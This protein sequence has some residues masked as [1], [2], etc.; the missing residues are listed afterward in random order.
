MLSFDKNGTAP[1]QKPDAADAPQVTLLPPDAAD[2]ERPAS[3]PGYRVLAAPAVRLGARLL[4]WLAIL[5]FGMTAALTFGA[6]LHG[7]ALGVAYVVIGL[8]TAAYE[9][10]MVWRY[11]AT[12]GKLSF[13]VQVVQRDQ[14][15]ET[16]GFWR[17]TA[18]WATRFVPSV[19]PFW[20]L[21]DSI[22]LLW[23]RP[24]YQCPHDKAAKTVV[25]R[26]P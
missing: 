19:V 21:F 25:V 24:G 13:R 16:P 17:S 7:S 10:L 1:P 4:D 22:W 11:G 6:F 12:L 18:R 5:L 23:D 15:A 14:P 3:G 26:R 8:I 9:P 20:L 2:A